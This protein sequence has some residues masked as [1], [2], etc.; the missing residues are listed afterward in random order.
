MG[1]GKT[2]NFDNGELN[3]LEGILLN[4]I[5]N[6]RKEVDDDDL[7]YIIDIY[8]KISDRDLNIEYVREYILT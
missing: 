6:Y 7:Q 4:H 1:N 2:L 5:A 8:N 3:N